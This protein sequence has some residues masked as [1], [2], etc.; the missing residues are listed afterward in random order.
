MLSDTSA[1]ANATINP[2][3]DGA[4][5]TYNQSIDESDDSDEVESATINQS[6]DG[7]NVTN[8]QSIDES[9]SDEVESA[10]AV[11]GADNQDER[12][13]VTNNLYV[14][15]GNVENNEIVEEDELPDN[16]ACEEMERAEEFAARTATYE[17]EKAAFIR[18]AKTEKVGGLTWTVIDDVRE[19]EVDTTHEEYTHVGCRGFEFVERNKKRMTEQIG[20]K[21]IQ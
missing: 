20:T 15:L 4:N 17:N 14:L 5:A 3:I 21:N 19:N 16:I 9:D 18:N 1:G 2:S 6:I 11:D 12:L 13:N 8:N 7:V 10:E